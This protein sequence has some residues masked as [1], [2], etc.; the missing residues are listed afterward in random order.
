MSSITRKAYL[1]GE[2]RMP[3]LNQGRITVT[4][5]AVPALISF[6]IIFF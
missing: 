1:V 2:L 6:M 5:P 3:V 4:P